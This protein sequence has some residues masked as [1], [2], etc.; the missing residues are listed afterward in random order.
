MYRFLVERNTLGL[1]AKD[2]ILTENQLIKNEFLIPGLSKGIINNNC[3]GFGVHCRV[4]C[5]VSTDRR[6]VI[7]KNT[8]GHTRGPKSD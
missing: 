7:Y 5:H 3:D 4:R 6:G 8:S 2:Y 1:H